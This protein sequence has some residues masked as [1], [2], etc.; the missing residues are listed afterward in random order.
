MLIVGAMKK[1]KP[2]L[3]SID[4]GSMEFVTNYT[5]KKKEFGNKFKLRRIPFLDVFFASGYGDNLL[6]SYSTSRKEFNMYH[7][8]KNVYKG[9]IS[10]C[11]LVGDSIFSV[12]PG[13][14]YV[15]QIRLRN[16]AA[17][18]KDVQKT[19]EVQDQQD[20]QKAA[21]R[22]QHFN[23]QKKSD[24]FD[25]A[26][27]SGANTIR[28][29]QDNPIDLSNKMEPDTT[30]PQDNR[31]I[32]DKTK[33]LLENAKSN[34][35]NEATSKVDG[36]AQG[37]TGGVGKLGDLGFAKNEPSAATKQVGKLMGSGPFF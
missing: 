25:K 26:I 14:S 9:Q 15:H 19:A 20:L 16:K 23:T 28:D 17:Y 33:G 2:S 7:F 13:N 32:I 12:S 10:D 29:K 21:A 35:T 36:L 4:T 22:E 1:E 8:F 3:I 18:Q 6:A 11:C 27:Q 30:R 34:T 24:E 31:G 5:I 37:N